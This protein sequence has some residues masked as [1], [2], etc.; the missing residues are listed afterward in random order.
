MV[1]EAEVAADESTDFDVAETAGVGA[2]LTQVDHDFAH[3][4]TAANVAETLNLG[5]HLGSAVERIAA[6]S[7]QGSEGVIA[8]REA[9]WLI[10][11]YVEILERRPIG[12]D[13]HLSAARLAQAGDVIA[14]L[15]AFAEALSTESAPADPEPSA[16]APADTAVEPDPDSSAAGRIR[17]LSPDI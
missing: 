15:K 13:L 10:Q 9:A 2:A 7:N 14:G 4:E 17:R 5:F 8:L 1:A 12:A 11:R 3:L 6:A 16:A